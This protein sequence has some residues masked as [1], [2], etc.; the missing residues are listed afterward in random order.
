M[1]NRVITWCM[2]NRFIA[3][4]FL[5]PLLGTGV[6]AVRNTPIDAIPDIGVNQQIVFVDWPGRSPKDVEDQVVYPLTTNLLGIPGVEV[7][8]SN[9]MF[10]FGMINIIFE[11]KIDFYW[12]RTRVLERLNLALKDLPE[13][14]V[15][16]LGPDATAL[17]Q[18][19]W[20][21]I[22]NGYYCP[23]HLTESYA[24][25][26]KCPKDG[27]PL[28]QSPYNLAE[29][30]SLQ[31]WFVKFQLTAVKGVSEVA[32]VGG[33]VKQYQIDV[34]PNKMLAYGVDMMKLI[35]AV[36]KSNIDVGAK[37]IEEG[38]MEFVIRGLGFIKGIEDI[39]NIVIGAHDG[40][41]VYVR[42]IGNV[43]L[44]PEFRRGALVKDGQETTGGIV[45]M[46]YGEN[47]LEVIKG[48]KRRIEE[49]KTGLPPGVRLVGY[50]D[51]SNLIRR[52]VNTLQKALIMA[53][54]IAV[55][56]ILVFMGQIRSSSI[57]S[58]ILPV[59]ILLA[60]LVMYLLKVPSNIM[61]LGGLAL[62]IGV[63]VD[64]GIVM[65]ENISRHFGMTSHT[66]ARS[67]VALRAAHEVG[68]PIFFS[69]LI[70]IAAFMTIFTLT[71][72]SGKLFKP[73]A[74]T[75]ISAMGGAAILS[76]TVI[77]VL[78]VL[79]LGRRTR[80]LERNPIARA[81]Q[82]AYRPIIGISLNHGVTVLLLFLF[83]MT[84]SLFPMVGARTITGPLSK[85]LSLDK[86]HGTHK[87]FQKLEAI[88]PG[89]KSEFMPPLNEGDLL[90]MPVLLPGASLSLVKDVL[91]RQ[92]SN[93]NEFPE[94]VTVV[95]KL[96]RAETPTDPAP[97]GMIESII[98]LKPEDQ[99]RSGMT[100][101]QLIK[102]IIHKTQ[103]AGVTPI[104]T[105]P[106]R[107]RIDML[108]T[109]IQTPV[110]IKI[111]GTDLE[112]IERLAVEIENV[113][114]EIPGAVNPYAE[115]VGNK[116]YLEIAI[117]RKQVARHGINVGDVQSLIMTAIGGMNITT[118][119]EGRERY[120][121]RVRYMRELRDNV[122]AIKRIFVDSPFG[123]KVP[124]SQLAQ[125]V[126]V[127]GPAKIASENTLL[128]ARIFIDVDTETTGIVDFVKAADPVIRETVRFPP[129]YFITW[130]GQYEY[131]IE[132]RKRLMIIVPICIA[133]IF[134]LLYLKFKSISSAFILLIALPFAFIGGIWLQFL[135]GYKFSTA[136]WVGYIALFGVTVEDGIVMVEY[137]LQRVRSEGNKR[138]LKEI[139]IDAALL[140]VRP[141][142]M[143]TAT[144]ILALM[145][146]M[147]STGA[148]SEV[149]K[150]I[151]VPT[152]GGIF[153]ATLTNLL[154]IPVLFYWVNQR[155]YPGV[156]AKEE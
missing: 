117:D 84:I 110:G 112:E 8:R 139:I 21:T 127:P 23:D 67:A 31:D 68:A 50:Y 9:S 122:E 22:E 77:P 7:I 39:E 136:V 114:R 87:V 78:C 132:S 48:V 107:N 93:I 151:A 108:A 58:V 141:I 124:L 12:S 118:T 43:L 6:W 123:Y 116:P 27:Q 104:M 81:L 59:G 13:G 57:I 153:T 152:V 32:S 131:E 138:P 20:Y 60:F 143:T 46:R 54:I 140:R 83:F 92:T 15:P 148:G 137:L 119:V 62:S 37:V 74:L 90:Y 2:E 14:I 26:G 126:R 18:I 71:G 115:R 33:Y 79:I 11:D 113:I 73:L 69:M 35:S 94:V 3:V 95:G 65:T 5:V 101:S 86:V 130:S 120:P 40:V 51:R 16:V 41:P 129:G 63:M 19:F 44:G 75:T 36:K 125:I 76:V 154:L 1:I 96:G 61:S 53:L 149:M 109:G 102:E 97:V 56:V 89:I 155:G 45:L 147:F 98:I 17:G 128:Y 145:A 4:M 121:V 111:F 135:L 24:A 72:Q 144:T 64:A 80:P 55:A 34:D 38:G 47:P 85:S 52:A 156:R 88:L 30:R 100:R 133:A 25:P 10:G 28:I 103:I 99:W 146:V 49:I 29:L 70:I 66:E 106:I 142:V 91:T 134:F 42:N 150:P 82:W 105:Q